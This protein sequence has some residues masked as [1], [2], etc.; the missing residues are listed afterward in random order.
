MAPDIG[1]PDTTRRRVNRILRV[2]PILCS[3]AAL[4]LVLGNFAAGVPRQ[5]DE[6]IA[7][8]LF[9]LLIAVQLPLVLLF[10]ATANWTRPARPVLVLIVQALAGA[11]ALGSLYWAGY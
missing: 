10:L 1:D 11:A 6:G 4:A 8:H 3:L 2:V 5:P 7:A 9:Q